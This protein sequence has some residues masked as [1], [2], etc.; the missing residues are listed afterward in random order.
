MLKK[1]VMVITLLLV[2][3]FLTSYEG[4]DKAFAEQK[5]NAESKRLPRDRRGRKSSMP[6]IPAF[7]TILRIRIWISTSAHWFWVPR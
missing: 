4:M 2:S 3:I 5:K 1:I 6:T 7:V